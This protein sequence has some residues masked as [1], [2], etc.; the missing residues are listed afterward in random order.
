LFDFLFVNAHLAVS[1]FPHILTFQPGLLPRYW[2]LATNF[3]AHRRVEAII[4]AAKLS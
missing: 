3:T 2:M 4:S 1:V